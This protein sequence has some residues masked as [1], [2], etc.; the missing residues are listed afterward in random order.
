MPALR[1]RLE[2]LRG[3]HP[4][5]H[6]LRGRGLL[7]GIELRAPDGER[8][9]AAAGV[10]GRVAE[11]GQGERPHDLLV[12]DA[13]RHRAHGRAHARAAARH[14]GRR[15]RRDGGPARRRADA[16]RVARCRA[17]PV[18]PGPASS[19]GRGCPW[20]HPTRAASWCASCRR[21]DR[22]D[23]AVRGMAGGAR[24]VR[25]RARPRRGGR[26]P[27]RRRARRR[28]RPPRRTARGRR[29]ARPRSWRAFTLVLGGELARGSAPPACGCLPWSGR[30]GRLTLAPKRRA[31]RRRRRRRRGRHAAARR[32]FWEAS[33]A[34]LWLAV[35]APRR[36]RPLAL[37]AGRRAAPAARAARRARGGGRRARAGRSRRA[38]GAAPG[39]RDASS[40]S[41]R[42]AA[43]CATRSS[44][45]CACSSATRR[46]PLSTRRYED[47]G[48]PEL[49][50]A[51]DVPG[52]PYAV[53]LD[54]AGVVGPRAP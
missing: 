28:S 42:P 22:E 24:R 44:R 8:F 23:R 12:P 19:L 29:G 25:P 10:C 52:T 34:V 30:P 6:S 9:A 14:L 36:A 50:A 35:A 39:T 41:R 37:P 45:A 7:Q 32:G 54:A 2:E 31:R 17:R 51:F 18:R 15:D 38:R 27:A 16:R 33:Y 49:H 4:I 47:D 26:R 13:G 48:G 3:R 20:S 43:R 1:D 5:V 11:R 53:Y 40:R 46:W 21:R